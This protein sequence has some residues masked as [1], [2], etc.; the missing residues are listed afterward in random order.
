MTGSGKSVH[1]HYSCPSSTRSRVPSI[2]QEGKLSLQRVSCWAPLWLGYMSLL[3]S[4]GWEADSCWSCCVSKLHFRQY[5][6]FE[7][8]NMLYAVFPSLILLD[9]PAQLSEIQENVHLAPENSSPGK[10]QYRDILASVTFCKGHS[11]MPRS[12]WQTQCLG[13]SITFASHSGCISSQKAFQGSACCHGG[14][15]HADCGHPS[16]KAGLR[17]SWEDEWQE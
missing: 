1:P 8:T 9:F 5:I 4:E 14:V 17:G 13:Q 7:N 6:V 16:S 10:E 2:S 12:L 3:F 11:L 15:C